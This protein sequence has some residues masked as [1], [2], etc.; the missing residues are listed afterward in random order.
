[1]NARAVARILLVVS[2]T[3][4]AAEPAS[5]LLNSAAGR[6]MASDNVGES[7]VERLSAE[8][9]ALAPLNSA[10]VQEFGDR[11][12]GRV[13]EQHPLKM[14]VRLKGAEPVPSRVVSTAV[15]SVRVTFEP[16]AEHSIADLQKIVASNRLRAFFPRAEG[17]GVNAAEGRIDI[18][19]V[20]PDVLEAYRARQREAERRM[21]IRIHFERT[22]GV[23]L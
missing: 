16:G 10:M 5:P 6:V 4:C 2:M 14:K 23:R 20:D 22:A 12:A 15:G 17:I 7:E 18:G 8:R 21:N 11:Y 3:S 19:V 13:I 9:T 1:M